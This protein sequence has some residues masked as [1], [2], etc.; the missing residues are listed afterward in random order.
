[1]VHLVQRRLSNNCML[2]T[3]TQ[4]YPCINIRDGHSVVIDI[5]PHM[6]SKSHP[7]TS[8]WFGSSSRIIPLPLPT[9]PSYLKLCLFLFFH[10]FLV[11][12]YFLTLHR[13]IFTEVRTK[14]EN[15]VP[16]GGK[17]CVCHIVLPQQT[18]TSLGKV[19]DMPQL[20]ECIPDL[21]KLCVQ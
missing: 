1:M 13:V 12:P 21:L 3:V 2:E 8:R 5:T 14:E 18:Q 17:N 6:P 7:Q 9:F 15:F 16:S 19:V 11:P 10:R 4:G 20:A